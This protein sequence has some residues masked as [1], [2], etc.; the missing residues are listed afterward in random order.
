MCC[1]QLESL[2]RMTP[3]SKSDPATDIQSWS[4]TGKRQ[5]SNV[6]SHLTEMIM[7]TKSKPTIDMESILLGDLTNKEEP[8]LID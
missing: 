3:A 2:S 6:L 1:L 8:F 5:L 4:S 7:F